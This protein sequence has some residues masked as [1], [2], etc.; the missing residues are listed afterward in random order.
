MNLYAFYG[1]GQRAFLAE[2][3]L[4]LTDEFN[5]LSFDDERVDTFE[6]GVKKTFG[7]RTYVN[8]VFF[9]NFIDDVQRHILFTERTITVLN[10]TLVLDERGNVVTGSRFVPLTRNAGD[11]ETW[12]FEI[13]GSVA[14]TSDLTV[15]GSAG[16]LEADYT[17]TVRDLNLDGRV[18]GQDEDLEIPRAPTWTYS[19]G[20]QH[21]LPLG[22]RHRLVS[23]VNYAYRDKAYNTTDNL[24]F[25]RQQKIVD[26]GMDLFLDDGQWVV[27]LYGRNLLDFARAGTDSA[28]VPFVPGGTTS[29][30]E[31]GR[32]FGLELTYNFRGV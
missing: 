7:P 32:T 17:R 14:V 23:R 27:G 2:R 16:Y 19:L 20:V 5:D 3:G 11:A 18:D 28:I 24:G 1:P 26:A 12:G 10:R 30:L 15:L 4:V 21:T 29:P 13:E 9:Y 8:A 22:L 25:N 31:R 6:L